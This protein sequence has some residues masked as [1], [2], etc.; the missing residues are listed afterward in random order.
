MLLT[1]R[2]WPVGLG[3]S[4]RI[5]ICNK[6]P[7][8]ATTGL[9][10]HFHV[11][12]CCCIKKWPPKLSGLKQTPLLLYL[13]ILW[14]RTSERDWPGHSSA[15]HGVHWGHSAGSRAGVEDSRWP[16]YMLGMSVAMTGRLGT[17]RTLSF[18]HDLRT[19][20]CGLSSRIVVRLLKWQLLALRG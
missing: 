15:P 6:L 1:C 2:S 12:T 19:P 13:T 16:H 4:P 18:P 9:W 10:D 7:G 11:V 8:D 5:C 3:S 17:A 20:P 14:V